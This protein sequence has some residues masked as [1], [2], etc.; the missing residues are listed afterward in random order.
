LNRK[1]RPKLLRKPTFAETR[2]LSWKATGT[3]DQLL[4]LGHAKDGEILVTQQ[5]REGHAWVLG[6]TG[7][8]KS[9]FLLH[10]IRSDADRLKSDVHLNRNDR[11]S[12]PVLFIDSTPQGS[13]AHQVLN[14]CGAINY[15]HVLLIDPY[16]YNETGK[17]PAINPFNYDPTHWTDSVDHLL[18]AFRILFEVEDLSR[19]AYITTYLR[20]LLSLFHY[21]GLTMVDLLPFTMPFDKDIAETYD[22]RERREEIFDLVRAKINDPTFPR[23]VR[24]IAKKHLTDVII[25]F[26]NIPN[27]TREFGSTARRINQVVT[28]PYL[29][30]IFGHRE[31]IPFEDLIAEGWV[32]LINASTGE[33]VGDLESRFLAT[34]VIN[35]WIGTVKRMRRGPKGKKSFDKPSYIYVD[36]AELYATDKLVKCLDVERNSKIRLILSNHYPSQ[37][38][39][40]IEKAVRGNTHVKVAFY[41]GDAEDRMA[42]VKMLFGG[43]LSDRDVAYTLSSQEKREAVMKVG[44]RPSRIAETHDVPDSLPNETFLE[45]LFNSTNYVTLDEVIK[46]IN[47]RY[48]Q[49]KNLPSPARTAQPDRQTTRGTNGGNRSQRQKNP[50]KDEGKGT[51]A[52]EG[53]PGSAWESLFLE[54]DGRGEEK[55]GGKGGE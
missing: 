7:E 4:S 32:V 25:A 46:D 21:A 24:P 10:L 9:R 16:W 43:S 15:P 22:Y 19:T 40:K 30:V 18:D 42:E 48:A 41:M 8:G 26:K 11:R 47:D 51:R 12:C 17:L 37:F 2:E 54:S 33:N 31:G 52:K 39:R 6:S 49:T 50:P 5:E 14:Y 1:S 3:P 23:L 20:A 28:N 27:F 34:V 38:P 35:Q 36:E 29:N 53:N 44:K 13:N 55:S 45:N